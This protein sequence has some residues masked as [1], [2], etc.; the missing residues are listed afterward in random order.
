MPKQ[1]NPSAISPALYGLCDL[2][3]PFQPELLLPYFRAADLLCLYRCK[4]CTGT[5]LRHEASPLPQA[6]DLF[7]QDEV[8]YS[9]LGKPHHHLL[10]IIHNLY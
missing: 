6:N 2:R 10:Y 9:C 5:L 1:L 4:I 3:D 7:L 8:H